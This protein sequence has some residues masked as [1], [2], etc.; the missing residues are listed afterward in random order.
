MKKEIRINYYLGTL[1]NKIPINKK[2]L[3]DFKKLNNLQNKSTYKKEFVDLLLKTNNKNKYFLLKIG[4]NNQKIPNYCLCKNRINN[5]GVILRSLR[6]DRHWYYYYNQPHDYSF[7]KKINKI[8]WRG[9]TT[10]NINNEGNRFD[11]I[12]KWYKKNEN[13]DVGFSYICLSSKKNLELN[14]K[15]YSE[16]RKYVNGELNITE[17]LKY[18]YLLSIK[19]N[20]K[21]SGLNWKLNSNSVILMVKPIISSWL[22]EDLLI[23]N[24]HYVEI[25]PDFS[26]LYEKYLWCENNQEKCIEIINNANKFMN[27]FKNNTKE[28]ELEEEVLNKYFFLIS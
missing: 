21:D 18:K 24:F 3:L 15:I 12:K 13:I 7:N 6:F 27:T 20:D 25:K 8:F 9:T 19:G 4:D 23:P 26:D 11:L 17:F 1:I 2:L 5:D 14:K 16:Y 22:M 10:G 28:R